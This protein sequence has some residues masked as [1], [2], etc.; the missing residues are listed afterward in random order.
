MR[1][2]SHSWLWLL[3]LASFTAPLRADPDPFGAAVAPFVAKHCS[4]CH[5]PEKKKGDLVLGP[6]ANAVAAAE[7]GAAWQKVAKKLRAREM[8]PKGRPQPPDAE[9]EA[10]LKWI[11]DAVLRKGAGGKPD[12][13]RV[14][15][16]RLN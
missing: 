14:T 12:P 16:R 10:V 9:V 11:D 15:I 2:P 1:S 13:G 3:P 6:Y 8:P 5:N 4:S 7:D